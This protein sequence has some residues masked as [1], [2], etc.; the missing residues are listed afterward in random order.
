LSFNQL[1]RI[2]Q[3]LFRI[4]FRSDFKAAIL[5]REMAALFHLSIIRS[6]YIL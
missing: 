5:P 6:T 1:A 2:C 4:F 3:T